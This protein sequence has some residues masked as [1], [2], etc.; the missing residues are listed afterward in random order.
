MKTVTIPTCA[1]P[2]IV[3][4]NGV[5]HTF[6]AG[7]TVEVTDEVA[8]VILQHDAAHNKAT[9]AE[10]DDGNDI[11]LDN[12]VEALAKNG[13]IGYS[14]YA[15]SNMG[16]PAGNADK[17]DTLDGELF[18]ADGT[19]VY[20]G[21]LYITRGVE[22]GIAN[23]EIGNNKITQHRLENIETMVTDDGIFIM[24]ASFFN[25]DK[26][27]MAISLP[28]VVAEM[29]G[30]STGTYLWSGLT[31]GMQNAY[32]SSISGHIFEKI[33]TID[34]KYLP[35]SVKGGGSGLTVVE[36]TTEWDMQ[37]KNVDLTDEEDATL[38][39]ATLAQMPIILKIP[40]PENSGVMCTPASYME[41]D[42]VKAF[43]FITDGGAY[44]VADIGNGWCLNI[45]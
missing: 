19:F 29:I 27:V 36:L 12:L 6:P 15:F 13:N 8:E 34:E 42:G 33:K 1:N 3:F 44:M 28:S 9:S 21:E 30:V 32:I 20:S 4:V 38:N 17:V 2:F 24:Y 43:M 7:A 40:M 39:A 22:E 18:E 14:T 31:N 26:K 11:N 25:C 5:K 35:D 16:F 37:T 45:G 41:T 23:V 10:S